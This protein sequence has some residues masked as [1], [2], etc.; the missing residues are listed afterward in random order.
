MATLLFK[1]GRSVALGGNQLPRFAAWFTSGRAGRLADLLGF[2]AVFFF[3]MR[4]GYPVVKPLARRAAFSRYQYPVF[5][6]AHEIHAPRGCDFLAVRPTMGF[7]TL[8][9]RVQPCRG[10][11]PRRGVRPVRVATRPVYSAR[12]L[13][14]VRIAVRRRLGDRANG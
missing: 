12:V 7:D 9:R 11:L 1:C 14:A 2:F 10:G 3:A 13:H 6:E 4:A 5:G 8:S